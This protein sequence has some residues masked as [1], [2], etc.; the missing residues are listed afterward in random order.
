M[1]TLIAR[2]HVDS[3]QKLLY[4]RP[5]SL[6]LLDKQSYLKYLSEA[7]WLSLSLR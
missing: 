2:P 4:F 1:G 6:K 7:C 3:C 5:P